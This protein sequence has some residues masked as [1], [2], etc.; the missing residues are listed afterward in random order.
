MTLNLHI[1]II[2]TA[3]MTCNDRWEFTRSKG[4]Y[5]HK[6][7]LQ[8]EMKNVQFDIL[9]NSDRSFFIFCANIYLRTE[10]KHNIKNELECPLWIPGTNRP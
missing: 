6:N 10:N 1:G 3:H 4:L 5:T 2:M 8:E 7:A 9:I